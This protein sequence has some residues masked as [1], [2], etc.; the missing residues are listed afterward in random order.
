MESGM[1]EFTVVALAR[2]WEIPWE[3]AGAVGS[4]L[5]VDWVSAG[6]ADDARSAFLLAFAGRTGLTLDDA[7]VVAV[8]GGHLREGEPARPERGGQ[9]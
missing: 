5:I 1:Q 9:P 6:S 3:D 8:F 4:A 7:A 2:P